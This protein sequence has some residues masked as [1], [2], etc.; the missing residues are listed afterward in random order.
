MVAWGVHAYCSHALIWTARL[1]YTS[2]IVA[3]AGWHC[4]GI[5]I[6]RRRNRSH[7][8]YPFR[9][10]NGSHYIDANEQCRSLQPNPPP[11]K[12]HDGLRKEVILRRTLFGKT[13]RRR[14]FDVIFN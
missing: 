6:M 4:R 13:F 8:L 10:F 1:P 7:L 12:L 3:N 11:D 5:K 2:P 14:A 9:R